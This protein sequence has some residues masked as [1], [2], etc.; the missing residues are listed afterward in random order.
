V[1]TETEARL[2]LRDAL[3]VPADALPV[4]G[5]ALPF[6]GT[7]CAFARTLSVFVAHL[8]PNSATPSSFSERR[9]PLAATPS[10][11][12]EERSLGAGCYRPA[13]WL[14]LTATSIPPARASSYAAVRGD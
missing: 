5:D 13:G 9:D 2:A 11:L 14:A 4:R 8:Q 7:L 6:V 1:R 10:A 3:P 12:R